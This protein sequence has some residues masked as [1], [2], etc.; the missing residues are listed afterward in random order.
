MEK[1]YEP[2]VKELQAQLAK[3][4]KVIER[5]QYSITRAREIERELEY[6]IKLRT[7]A[8]Q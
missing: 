4:R 7:G 5:A 3:A 2:S 1:P 6:Q 8:K